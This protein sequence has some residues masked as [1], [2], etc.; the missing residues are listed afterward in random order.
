MPHDFDNQPF[1]RPAGI[2]GRLA[3]PSFVI[4][5]GVAENARFLADK[6]DEVGLCLFETRACL[7]YGPQDLPPYA[8]T[9]TCP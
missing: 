5:A 9:P 3:A 8:G 2:A 6:V 7:S 1:Q 4:P